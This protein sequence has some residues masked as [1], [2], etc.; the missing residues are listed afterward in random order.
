M[1]VVIITIIAGVFAG[2][3]VAFVLLRARGRKE[4]E[5]QTLLLL[6]QQINDLAKTLDSKLD[7]KLGE[8]MRM[9][10][11]QSRESSKA[12]QNVAG[13][14]GKVSEQ[15]RQVINVASQLQNLQDILK[16]PKQRGILGEF[17]LETLLRNVLPPDS[18]Q[19]QYSFEDG[20]IVDAI[21][22]TPD[23]IIP[24]DS[25]FS[26]ENYTRILEEGDTKE[27][28][29]LERV[30]REDLKTRIDETAK[31]IKQKEGTLD[32]AIMFIPSEAIYYDLLINQVGTIKV[33]ARSLLDYASRDK[34][35]VIV[36]PTTFHAYLM[37]ILQGLRAFKIEQSAKEIRKNV[38][39]LRRHL[40]SHEFYLQKMGNQLGTVVNTYNAG[41]K[42][43]K[44][45]DKDVYRITGDTIGVEPLALAKPEEIE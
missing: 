27:K 23:G 39:E 19:M 38:E 36:S 35:V 6:H 7:M 32:F 43:F 42:E 4:P 20:T 15:N 44:K 26:L 30:F 45:I 37:T 11:I 33:N 40:V 5:E 22:K 2:G 10:E 8:S 21:I 24:V 41:H 18:L 28:E 17:Y 31:Y 29:R 9:M 13:E 34:H 3:I 16:N 25:K 12:L 14:L 1:T